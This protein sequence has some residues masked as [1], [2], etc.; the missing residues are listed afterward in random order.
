MVGVLG[1]GTGVAAEP[2]MGVLGGV[3]ALGQLGV[4]LRL[5]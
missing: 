3:D 1:Q 5:L 2:R 4:M